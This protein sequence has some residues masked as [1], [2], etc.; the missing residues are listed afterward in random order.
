MALAVGYATAMLAV[1]VAVQRGLFGATEAVVAW[2]ST[3]L[4]VLAWHPIPA[5]VASAFL[6]EHASGWRWWPFVVLGVA[7]M[8]RTSGVRV[9]AAVLFAVHVLATL[10][11]EAILALR[12]DHGAASS[13]QRLLV[14]VGPSYLVVAALVIAV[15]EPGSGRWWRLAC[16]AAL[17]VLAPSLLDG[18]TSWQVAPVGHLISAALA[19]AC[20]AVLT[21]RARLA[22]KMGAL[23]G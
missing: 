15:I 3:N 4:S 14:D 7:T 10:A 16:A 5:L 6:T 17:A 12:I 9:T 19:V 13:T 20:W 8:A 2:C 18:L 23:T 11:S 21:R 22:T 1:D